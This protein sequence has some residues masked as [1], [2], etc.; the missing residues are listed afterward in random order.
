MCNKLYIWH[1]KSGVLPG[2]FSWGGQHVSGANGRILYVPLLK[3]WKL[4]SCLKI[5]YA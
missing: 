2:D 1:I 4:S 5:I 3:Q